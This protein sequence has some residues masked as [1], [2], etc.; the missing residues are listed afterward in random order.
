MCGWVWVQQCSCAFVLLSSLRSEVGA[1]RRLSLLLIRVP[2]RG[3][4][5][6]VHCV[7]YQR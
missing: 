5:T 7:A 1:Y 3:R 6:T 4:P 2:W